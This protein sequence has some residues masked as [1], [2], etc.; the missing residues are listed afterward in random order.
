MSVESGVLVIHC[1]DPRYQTAFRDFVRIQLGVERYALLAVPGGPQLLAPSEDL[2]KFPWV[3]WQ[4]VRFLGKL[5]HAARVILIA[6]DDCQWYQ[7]AR[8][9]PAPANL[10]ARQI[11]D[12]GEVSARLRE[13][14]GDAK[15]ERYYIRL[16]GEGAVFESV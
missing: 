8:F 1:S 13:R 11:Q 14:F 5:G 3:G 4:W 16:E 9:A 6:H 10:R 7:D 15:I 12:L 2:P